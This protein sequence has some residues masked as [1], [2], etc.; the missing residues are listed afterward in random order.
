VIDRSFYR[1]RYHAEQVLANFG[2]TLRNQL[3]LAQMSEQLL[4]VVQETMQPE[5]VSLWLYSPDRREE[6][7]NRG[8]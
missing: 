1:R 5:H 4:A 2:I 6:P 8:D 3:E 7:K